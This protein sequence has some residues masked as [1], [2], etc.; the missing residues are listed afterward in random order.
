MSGEAEC[1]GIRGIGESEVGRRK[2]KHR[3]KRIAPSVQKVENK[4]ITTEGHGTA[5]KDTV[6]KFV[7]S[8]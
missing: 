2:V 6:C 1:R 8:V 4:R 5:R 3:A 7:V